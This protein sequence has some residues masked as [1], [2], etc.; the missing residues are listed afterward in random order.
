MAYR[1]SRRCFLGG[2]TASLVAAPLVA[3]SQPTKTSAADLPEAF[4]KRLPRLMEWANV[5]GL[6][7]A[8]LKEGELAWSQGFGVTK[9]GESTAVT[10]DT[11]FAAAS[12]SKPV[13]AYAILRMRDEKLIDIDRPL[14][15]YLPYP[16]LPEGDNAKLITARHALSHSSGLQ[17]WRFARTDKLEF[18]FQPGEG[19]Q[20]SGEGFYYLLRVLEQITGRGFEEYMQDRVLKPLG[21]AHSTFL[22]TSATES[23]M[24]WGHNGRMRPSEAFSAQRGRQMMET[25]EQWKKPVATWKHADAVKALTDSNKDASTFPNFLLPNS[26]GSLISSVNEYARFLGRILKPRRDALDV[27]PASLRDMLSPQTKVNSAISWGT[28]VGLESYEGRQMLWHWGDNG[29]FKAFMMG[30]VANGSGLIVFTNAQNGHKMWQR[31]VAETM[32]RDHPST[33]FFM[34]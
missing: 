1:T 27:S 24:S 25:A 7:I 23:R 5:P 29:N 19:F 8:L 17:N 33:F 11:L 12:L 10:A 22:W 15:N 31:I 18:A 9:A 2:A 4:L 30:D 20:Y 6:A 16:E 32:G 21:M 28:G 13:V 14:W 34:T 3:R 26:A